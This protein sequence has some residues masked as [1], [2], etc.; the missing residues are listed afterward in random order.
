MTTDEKFKAIIGFI[1]TK[2]GMDEDLFA[3]LVELVIT[4]VHGSFFDE[5]D[6]GDDR[7][8]KKATAMTRQFFLQAIE[9]ILV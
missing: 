9:R 6:Y 1:H 2:D 5:D 8:F 4:D 7:A 3:A